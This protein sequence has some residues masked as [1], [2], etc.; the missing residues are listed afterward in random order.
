MLVKM[1]D[2]FMIVSIVLCT[3][4]FEHFEVRRLVS[5]F[6]RIKTMRTMRVELFI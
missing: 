4:R 5:D 6:D 2:N 3:Y 1:F